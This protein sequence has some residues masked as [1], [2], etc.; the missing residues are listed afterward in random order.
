MLEYNQREQRK[1][2]PLLFPILVCIGER[3]LLPSP[4]VGASI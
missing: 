1:E 3:F 4:I 2:N